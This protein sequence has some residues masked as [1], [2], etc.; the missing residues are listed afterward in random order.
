VPLAPRR[1]LIVAALFTVTFCLSMPIAAYGV[2]L[3]VFAD[4]FGWTRGAIATALSL[5]LLLGGVAGF[6]LGAVA[7]RHGPRVVLVVT[8]AMAGTAFAA[9][10]LVDALWQLHLLV[11]V[12]GGVGMSTFYL[13]SAST[14]SQWFDAR[15]GLALALVLIGFNLGYISAGPLAAWLIAG[16]GWRAAYA[17]LGAGCG[18]IATL[19]AATVRRPRPH[20]A[21]VR[22][23]PPV[24]AEAP[25]AGGGSGPV[26]SVTVGQALADVRQWGLNLSWSLLGAL[27]FMLN[28]HIVPFARDRGIGLAAA[29]LALTA[30]GL[31]SVTGRLV[32]GALSDRIGARTTLRMGYVV[33]LLGLLA[34]LMAPSHE[35]LLVALALFGAGFAA[36]DNMIVKAVPDIFG[37]R[38]LGAIM[39]I[40][41]LGWR[42]GAAVGPAAAGFLHDATGSY[43]LAFGAAPV[44]VLASWGLFVLA[45]SERRRV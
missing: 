44:V 33:Q 36:T 35:V 10:S 5:N 23:R 4:T 28:V 45:S 16:L 3:P 14:V 19:A 38:A 18:L 2:F 37:M 40:L 8:A 24:V 9:I 6:A 31:G 20:E 17:V 30:Y 22:R 32:A 26:V 12:L 1:W 7:D 25:A 15:R 11:G 21:E 29:S 42:S 41:T 13:L 39:G 43:M 34:V 27:T